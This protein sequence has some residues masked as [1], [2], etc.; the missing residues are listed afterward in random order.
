MGE[1]ADWGP[2]VPSLSGYLETCGSHYL[3]FYPLIFVDV[4]G[5][6]ELSKLSLV[7][8]RHVVPFPITR[9]FT[10]ITLVSS[11]CNWTP[12]RTWK[13]KVGYY[14]RVFVA[15][16]VGLTFNSTWSRSR[17]LM[18]ISHIDGLSIILSQILHVHGIGRFAAR[19]RCD[20]IYITI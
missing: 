12:P 15:G 17:R 13:I 14:A 20:P 18:G 19:L 4:D 5:C 1:W 16:I 10:Q 9:R 8:L 2:N 6:W 7:D 11:H 3:M